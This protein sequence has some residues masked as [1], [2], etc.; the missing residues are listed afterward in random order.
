MIAFAPAF[1]QVQDNLGRILHIGGDQDGGRTNGIVKAAHD[2][3]MRA[4]IAGES[5]DADTGVLVSNLLTCLERVV[6]GVVIDG[7][8]FPVELLRIKH[9]AHSLI[10]QRQI[11]LFIETGHDDADRRR[12]D[13]HACSFSWLDQHWLRAS[14]RAA[15]TRS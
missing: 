15:T 3:D 1:E 11:L 12:T 9:R 8:Q 13:G 7:H 14:L 4:D 10:Q 2:G 6:A 5:N